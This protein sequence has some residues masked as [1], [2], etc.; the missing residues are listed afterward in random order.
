[1]EKGV[2]SPTRR[3]RVIVKRIIDIVGS[4]I[5]LIVLAVPFL[6]IAIAIKLESK[7]PVIFRQKRAA[8][9]GKPFYMVKF[10]TMVVDAEHMGLGF[11]VAQQDSRITL[12]GAVIRDWGLDE[13]PQLY[14]ALKGQMCL[15]EP[16][17][18]RMGQIEL[19]TPEEQKQML[20]NPGLTGW[21]QVNGRNAITWKQRRRARRSIAYFMNPAF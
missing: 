2:T 18:V 12:V 11:E 17:A 8:V 4:S 21:A 15:V 14:N 1:M 19:F 10:R 6:L 3:T 20:I 7:G 5:G 13:L 16:R 9:N